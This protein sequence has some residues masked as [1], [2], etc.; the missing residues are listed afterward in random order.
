MAKAPKKTA[1]PDQQEDSPVIP[2]PLAAAVEEKDTVFQAHL[3]RQANHF[4]D[5]APS[6]AKQARADAEREAELKEHE[7]I[8]E[9]NRQER[10]RQQKEQAAREERENAVSLIAALEEDIPNLE[11]AIA[12]KKAEL[13]RLQNLV[14]E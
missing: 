5:M 13:K 4:A 9:R 8:A 7:I 3:V 12:A 11:D 1:E 6:L 10:E 2:A 14:K